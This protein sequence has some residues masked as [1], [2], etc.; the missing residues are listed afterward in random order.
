[1]DIRFVVIIINIKEYN[2]ITICITII[3]C[4]IV[5]CSA[6]C[7]ISYLKITNNPL[8]YSDSEEVNTNKITTSYQMV[9]LFKERYIMPYND[10]KDL[11]YIGGTTEIRTFLD[12]LLKVLS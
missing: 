3:I 7:Y 6:L 10:T 2:M 5:A 8:L 1:M 9:K 12:N 4:I 11:A